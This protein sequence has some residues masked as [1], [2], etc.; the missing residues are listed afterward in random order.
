MA[1]ARSGSQFDAS[2]G[3]LWA[4]LSGIAQHQVSS[5]WKHAAR[6]RR[7]EEAVEHIRAGSE[8]EY[9]LESEPA[10][11][12]ERQELRVV[13]RAVLAELQ[14]DYSVLLAAKYC[15]GLSV[16]EIQEQLGG[17]TEAIRSRL[18]RARREFRRLFERRS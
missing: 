12:V 2:R 15:D 1:A 16:G 18:A 14:E 5:H 11:V 10:A 17:S 6:V 3:T 7:I 8:A 9:Q 4:W 13:I